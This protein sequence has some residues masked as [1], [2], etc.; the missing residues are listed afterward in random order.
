M[1]I[2]TKFLYFA[3]LIHISLDINFNFLIKS[4]IDYRNLTSAF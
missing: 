2:K 1:K 4:T 3:I